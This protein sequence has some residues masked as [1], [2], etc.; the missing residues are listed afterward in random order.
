MFF[1]PLLFDHTQILLTNRKADDKDAEGSPQR[2]RVRAYACLVI[3]WCG[4]NFYFVY[5]LQLKQE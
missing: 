1:Y 5:C 2:K 4:T 3:A